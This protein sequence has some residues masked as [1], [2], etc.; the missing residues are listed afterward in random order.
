MTEQQSNRNKL[1]FSQAEG[2]DPLPQD[3]RRD[4][5]VGTFSHIPLMASR[6][7]RFRL[8]RVLDP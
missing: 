1:T 2:I 6:L 8:Q 4:P 3:R 5:P 7:F